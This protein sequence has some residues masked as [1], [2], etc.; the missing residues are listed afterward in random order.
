MVNE[1]CKI[2]ILHFFCTTIGCFKASTLVFMNLC[3]NFP[4]YNIFSL[5]FPID[6]PS[7]G[8]GIGSRHKENHDSSNYIL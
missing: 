8:M 7:Q 4:V 6:T 2:E 5:E 3:W 1:A